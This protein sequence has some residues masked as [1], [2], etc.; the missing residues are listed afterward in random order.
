MRGL[1]V[2][3]LSSAPCNLSLA[4]AG[5]ERTVDSRVDLRAL[6]QRT[7]HVWPIRLEA[8]QDTVAAFGQLLSPDEA[9]RA[10][11]FCFDHLQRRYV[12]ARGAL[13]ILLAHYLQTSANRIA[14][15][16]GEKGKPRVAAGGIEFNISHSGSLALLAFT[17]QCEIG[18]DV[19]ELRPVPNYQEIAERFFRAD[20]AA[21]VRSSPA[22]EREHAFLVCW[23]RKEA[24][25]KAVGD[26]LSAPLNGFRVTVRRGEP[27][28]FLH[29]EVSPDAP[30]TLHDL[31]SPP[32]YAAALAYNET[33]RAV[34]RQPL[35]E[36]AQ[37]LG[38]TLA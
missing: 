23:T 10:G 8:A 31:G 2:Q 35:T 13:R 20:E 25:L 26:G 3:V 19:E 21:E 24:Y 33:P 14:F 22:G 29:F 30:W 36:P 1:K 4:E 28:R 27:A 32:R 16:Y 5:P 9:I 34:H 7:I 17:Q 11:R 38:A 37:L 12:L 18:I 15:S 6:D